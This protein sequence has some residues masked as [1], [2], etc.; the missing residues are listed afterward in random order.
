MIISDIMATTVVTVDVD[1]NLKVVKD[2]FDA[3]LFH[4]L[5]AVESAKLVGIVSDRDLL[6]AISPNIGTLAETAKDTATLNKHV[7]Q[8]MSRNPMT[9]TPDADIYDAVHIFNA[10]PVSCI[11]VI[12][13]E[14]IPLGII[15][16]RDIMQLIEKRDLEPAAQT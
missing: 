11:A 7:H 15:T 10:H 16:W 3:T 4:H 6:R 2:I 12:D 9:L 13:D 1:D 14:N 5:L 8:I